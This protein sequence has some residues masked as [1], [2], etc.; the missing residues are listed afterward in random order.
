[1]RL[2]LGMI[3]VLIAVIFALYFRVVPRLV[4]G[5]SLLGY[6]AVG[7]LV[8]AFGVG[9]GYFRRKLLRW[10]LGTP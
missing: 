3:A 6:V 10:E 5:S 8:G 9:E 2:Y 4:G 1:M 7:L